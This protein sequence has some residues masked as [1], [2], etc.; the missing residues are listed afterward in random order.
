MISFI[1]ISSVAT[2]LVSSVSL[3]YG[4]SVRGVPSIDK[5]FADNKDVKDLFDL[6]CAKKTL[7]AGITSAKCIASK[8]SD[9]KSCYACSNPFIENTLCVN[10]DQQAKVMHY[11]GDYGI[12]CSN[13]AKSTYYKEEGK[14][15]EEPVLKIS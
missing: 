11:G 4:K 7:E 14:K 2:L 12:S 13:S 3:T 5:S 9:G 6:S 8:D 1:R 10:E 15:V